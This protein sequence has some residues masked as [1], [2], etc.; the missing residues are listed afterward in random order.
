MWYAPAAI[1]GDL[2][3]SRDVVSHLLMNDTGQG[4]LEKKMKKYDIEGAVRK[5][6]FYEWRTFWM[7]PNWLIPS[8]SPLF[9]K[10]LLW[11]P[12]DIEQSLS[13][14]VALKFHSIVRSRL[15]DKSRALTN[16]VLWK[17]FVD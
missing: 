10:D 9:Q 11:E 17:S 6:P 7:G 2:L 15:S 3:P 12:D 4:S 13:I 14:P 5:M 8:R 1:C 16:R